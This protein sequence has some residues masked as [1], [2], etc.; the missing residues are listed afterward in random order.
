MGMT[1]YLA[2]EL[3]HPKDE[4]D[5]ISI[6]LKQLEMP[7]LYVEGNEQSVIRVPYGEEAV[8]SVFAISST[9]ELYYRWEDESDE[10]VG[11]SDSYTFTPERNTTV[12]CRISDG[13]DEETARSEYRVFDVRIENHLTVR[14]DGEYEPYI[15]GFIKS[16]GFGDPVTLKVT[17]SADDDSRLTYVWTREEVSMVEDEDGGLVPWRE[18]VEIKGENTNTYEIESAEESCKYHCTVTDRFGNWWSLCFDLR[19]SNLSSAYPE[20]AKEGDED[21]YVSADYGSI[22]PG[23][24]ANFY[25][26]RPIP[27]IDFIPYAYTT[28][29]VERAFLAGIEQLHTP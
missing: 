10:I 1:Y 9:G 5:Y 23:K 18:F 7:D 19:V 2:A 11:T 12:I 14:A 16:V 15:G 3:A 27:S 6:S 24:V 22:A 8:L 20:G 17:A 13:P 21:A 29:V 4:D 25:I 26:T 28:P